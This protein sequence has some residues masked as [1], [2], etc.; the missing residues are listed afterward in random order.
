MCGNTRRREKSAV[1]IVGSVLSS[2]KTCIEIQTQFF[3]IL[4][5]TDE[6]GRL[7]RLS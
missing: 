6:I 5:T 3:N 2:V 1:V 4:K 7:K